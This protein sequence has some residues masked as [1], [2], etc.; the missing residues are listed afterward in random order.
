MNDK[1]MG[2]S[3]CLGCYGPTSPRK[4][5]KKK[6]RRR[7]GGAKKQLGLIYSG[8]YMKTA[9][10]DFKHIERLFIVCE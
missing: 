8:M 2:A 1:G 6:E 7:K 3:L 4:L 9:V 5:H 10:E